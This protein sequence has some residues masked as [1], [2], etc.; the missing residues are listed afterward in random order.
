MIESRLPEIDKPRVEE[1]KQAMKVASARKTYL[2]PWTGLEDDMRKANEDGVPVLG[3]GSLIN[4]NSAARTLNPRTLATCVPAIVFGARP[5]VQLQ[6][7]ER[8]EALWAA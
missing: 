8:P 1:I 3:Y 7:V 6:A 4:H 2:Y 5:S